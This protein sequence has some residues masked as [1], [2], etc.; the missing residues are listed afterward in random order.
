MY[1]IELS[2]KDE[3]NL[4]DIGE[5]YD[6]TMLRKTLKVTEV[7]ED[8]C[9]IAIRTYCIIF[10]IFVFSMFESLFFWFYITNQEN[11]VLKNQMK[12]AKLIGDLVCENIDLDVT[13]LLVYFEDEN[14]KWNN[15]VPLHNTFVLNSILLGS[16]LANLFVLKYNK[17]DLLQ[18]HSKIYKNQFFLYIVLFAYEYAFFQN[19]I[20]NYHP[21]S[22][23]NLYKNVFHKCLQ[24]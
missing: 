8:K 11:N 14:T 10:H 17:I 9:I 2:N 22:M 18:V 15:N 21:T 3:A 5:L 19:V 13:S 6:N 20:Y 12:D 7:N 24:N 4:P 23:V 16:L 1:D